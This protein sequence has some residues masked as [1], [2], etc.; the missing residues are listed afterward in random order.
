M[1]PG[2]HRT[3][4]A[5]IRDALGP[6]VAIVPF[7]K[8][9]FDL[10]ALQLAPL[11]VRV[12][13]VA[14]DAVFAEGEVL[15]GLWQAVGPARAR[16]RGMDPAD[17]PAFYRDRNLLKAEVTGSDVGRAVVFFVSG[18]PPTTG[19]VLPVDGGLASAFPR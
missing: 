10:A 12:N 13:A 11:G 18:A 3:G 6:G 19:A 14:P 7:V 4:E 9:G 16:S 1:G 2:V 8:A 5:T 17:L 15:S